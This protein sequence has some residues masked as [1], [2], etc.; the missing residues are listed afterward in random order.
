[1]N[2]FIYHTPTKVV[3]ENGAEKHTGE[4]LKEAGAKKVLIHYGGGSVVRSGLLD[5][6]KDSLNKE[7]IENVSLGGAVPNPLLSKVYEGIEL[8]KKENVDFILAVGGGSTIDSAKAMALGLA[9]DG[10]VWDFFDDKCSPCDSYPLAC[11]LTLAATGSEM[12]D[13]CV[14]T[15]DEG[16]LKRYTGHPNCI[17][18]FAVMNPELML[19]LP[20]YQTASG[21]VDILMHTME[22]Y[23][24]T[25]Q[26]LSITDY[27]AEGLMKCV[28][29]EAQKL[30]AN[31]ND[32][33]ARWNIMWAGS[34]SHN[35]LTG[36][37]GNGGDWAS[38]DIE[39]ELGGMF[40]VTHGAGLAAVWGSWARYVIDVIP[41]RFAKVAVNVFGIAP[42]TTEKE[43]ALKGIEAMEGFFRSIDMPIN[44]SQ[45]G[46][47]PTPE[48]I[49]EL[50]EKATHFGKCTV[51]SVIALQKK[52][53][54]AIFNMANEAK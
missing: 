13:S 48:Q 16:M 46:V 20:D 19:T 17:C 12:S 35:S 50:A 9:Y 51:G 24:N 28:I 39:H 18:K 38:H 53:I 4:L 32:L 54:M 2:S 36:C 6:V 10:D 33:E 42:C 22:R 14:I 25:T 52:D 3:F 21:C 49:D 1:M 23:F 27:V 41:H 47:N 37:G 29:E 30:K 8:C 31:P 26:N 34:L 40:D 11:V 45:L 5:R 15:K 7:G 44:L 43:T